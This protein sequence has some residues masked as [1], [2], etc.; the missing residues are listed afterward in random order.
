MYP[1][2]QEEKMHL[3]LNHQGVDGYREVCHVDCLGDVVAGT[4]DVVDWS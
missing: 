3:I 2:P 1:R 4:A